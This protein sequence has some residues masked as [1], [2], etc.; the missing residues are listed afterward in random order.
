MEFQGIR[1]DDRRQRI[2]GIGK[3]RKC[4]HF[5]ISFLNLIKFLRAVYALRINNRVSLVKGKA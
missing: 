1:A 2:L 5:F 3:I 4:N